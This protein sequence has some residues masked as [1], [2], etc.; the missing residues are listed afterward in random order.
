[1]PIKCEGEMLFEDENEFRLSPLT[2]EPWWELGEEEDDEDEEE[3]K[4]E[5]E[6]EEE[7]KEE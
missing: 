1:M 2:K 4:E 6:E 3:E 7:E 5:V